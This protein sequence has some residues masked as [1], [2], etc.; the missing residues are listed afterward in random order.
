M[1]SRNPLSAGILIP[2]C[3]G[4]TPAQL[5]FCF[6]PVVQIAPVAT[7]AAQVQL[8]C[9]FGDPIAIEVGRCGIADRLWIDYILLLAIDNSDVPFSSP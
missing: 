3:V 4:W 2:V 6:K 9:A 8:I 7:A 5:A 1:R